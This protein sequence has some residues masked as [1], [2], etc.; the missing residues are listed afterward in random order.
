VPAAANRDRQIVLAGKANGELNVIR[1]LATGNARRTAVDHSVPH[2]PR[3]LVSDVIRSKEIS[4]KAGAEFTQPIF[5]EH[6]S[7]CGHESSQEWNGRF[8]VEA[9]ISAVGRR[10]GRHF[11]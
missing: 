10:S 2:L 9:S 11:G 1:G 6:L 8:V 7:A 5:R 3:G 4:V